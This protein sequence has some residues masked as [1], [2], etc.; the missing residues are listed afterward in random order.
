M[1]DCR[2]LDMR[3]G[4]YLV[5]VRRQRPDCRNSQGMGFLRTDSAAHC[6]FLDSPMEDEEW[7]SL[8]GCLIAYKSISLQNNLCQVLHDME[9]LWSL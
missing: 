9:Y 5:D 3:G 6:T 8:A 4:V 1:L 7:K 2:L